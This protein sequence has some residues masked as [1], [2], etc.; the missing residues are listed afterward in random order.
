MWIEIQSWLEHL[1]KMLRHFLRGSVDWNWW[2]QIIAL[3][4][5]SVTSF[6]E[7]WI[8]IYYM[9]TYH[10]RL[11]SLPSR[12]CGLKSA[13]DYR[14][15]KQLNSH[16]L[17]GS[18][19]WNSSSTILAAYHLSHFLR[20]NVDWNLKGKW[21]IWN[22]W[23]TSFAEVWIEMIEVIAPVK[24]VIVTSFAEVWIEIVTRLGHIR[25]TRSLPSRKCG[26]KYFKFLL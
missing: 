21:G 8:E 16:F 6:A 10:P 15:N 1:Q 3:P 18:V 5:Y 24:A 13:K 20:G 14:R 22:E 12:K 19:D 9:A 7:V 17:R 4:V 11:K 23:V 25:Q 26:L 2:R